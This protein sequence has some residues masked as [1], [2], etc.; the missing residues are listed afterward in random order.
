MTTTLSGVS[1][2]QTLYQ[3]PH[4]WGTANGLWGLFCRGTTD[5]PRPE[6]ETGG[7]TGGGGRRDFPTRRRALEPTALERRLFLV[8]ST[9]S[10]TFLWPGGGSDTAWLGVLSPEP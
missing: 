4:L 3:E 10:G 2:V 6:E 7:V 9:E 5:V 1:V 8:L